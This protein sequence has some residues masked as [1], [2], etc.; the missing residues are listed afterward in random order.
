MYRLALTLIIVIILVVFSRIIYNIEN[1]SF[2]LND[3]MVLNKIAENNN[4]ARQERKNSRSRQQAYNNYKNFQDMENTVNEYTEKINS[5]K[6]ILRSEMPICRQIDLYP[7]IDYT[8]I[9]VTNPRFVDDTGV[10]NIHDKPLIPNGANC[11]DKEV[12]LF[13]KQ[14]G[15]CSGYLNGIQGW[16]TDQSTEE[17]KQ[18]NETLKNKCKVDPYCEFK[19]IDLRS[20][21]SAPQCEY[22]K[23]NHMC[24]TSSGNPVQYYLEPGILDNI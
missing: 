24:V 3:P 6:E 12:T 21:D 17:A 1:F 23:L 13:G 7:N 16:I 22:K 4:V 19:D 10:P 2:D 11:P 9:A 5:I 14:F 20:G 18:H 15:R 8:P